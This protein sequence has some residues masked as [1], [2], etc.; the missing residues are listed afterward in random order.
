MICGT[1]ARTFGKRLAGLRADAGFAT[2]YQFYH[3]NGGRRTFP[4]TYVHYLRIE[5]GVALPRPRWLR[6][7]LTALR[8]TPGAAGC[9][10]LFLAYLKD[11]LDT[12]EVCELVLAPLLC[13]HERAA[14]R[15][16]EALRW[17]KAE[18]AVHLT[19]E[20]FK[21]LAS[22]EAV[23]WCSEIMVNDRGS[24][25][26]E[27]A[28]AALGMDVRSIRVAF[29]KL[30]SAGLARET[31]GR[32]FKARASGKFQTFP[33]RLPGMGPALEAVQ[34][35]WGKMYRR[36]GKEVLSRVELIRA[37]ESSTRDYSVSLAEA[38]DA[39][40]LHAT[41]AKGEDTGLFLIEARIRKLTPF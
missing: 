17:M 16:A 19:P 29:A 38:L 27:E 36:R 23:Y 11:L 9:R 22:D 20:Q 18:H 2:A 6:I 1:M 13:R 3:R 37:S 10:E 33:G 39:A 32:R 40:N 8:L 25:T 7:F 12:E 31:S 4:F 28:A 26:A 35:Y 41:Q 21:F 14:A 34:R 30:K 24:W 5:K 15:G